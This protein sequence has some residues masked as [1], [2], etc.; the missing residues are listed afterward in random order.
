MS[1]GQGI[2]DAVVDMVKMFL[3]VIFLLFIGVILGGVIY[4]YRS[5]AGC[6][7]AMVELE[8]CRSALDAA[9]EEL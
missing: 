1:W 7:E 6:E 2:G 8:K 3:F 9:Q 4:H 5:V